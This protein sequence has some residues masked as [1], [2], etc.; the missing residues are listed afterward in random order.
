MPRAIS[1]S[2]VEQA[3]VGLHGLG[4]LEQDRAVPVLVDQLPGRVALLRRQALEHESGVGRVQA[5][6]LGFELDR[7]LAGD[8]RCT[9]SCLSVCS[10][11]TSWLT[12]SW[13]SISAWISL[14]V[15]SRDVWCSV[16]SCTAASFNAK[17][18]TP[19]LKGRVPFSRGAS[20]LIAP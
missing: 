9:S 20:P 18:V 12:I 1:S 7:V 8:Q 10:R 19:R 14:S 4:E 6:E 13:R 15:A 3:E 16:A 17:G 2:S 5:V 11:A